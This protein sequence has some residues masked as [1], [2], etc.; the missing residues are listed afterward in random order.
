MK[1]EIAMVLGLGFWSMACQGTRPEGL[2]VQGGLLQECPDKP[3]CVCSQSAK[4]DHK[5]ESLP[6]KGS[7][8]D[9]M[10]RLV[11]VVQAM[12]GS[13]IVEQKDDYLYVEFTSAL[14]RF[15]DDVEFYFPAAKNVIEV[16]SASRIG[17]S[18]FGVNRKRVE[19]IRQAL[20]K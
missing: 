1:K 4:A 8:Q 12:K 7:P 18:D 3:N 11:Q 2:G 10:Q 6:R 14:L 13:R 19:A 16:R 15:V 20:E 17:R 5:I 9:S